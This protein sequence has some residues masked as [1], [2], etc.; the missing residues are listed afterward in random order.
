MVVSK[1]SQAWSGVG[2]KLFVGTRFLTCRPCREPGQR[3]LTGFLR[4]PLRTPPEHYRWSGPPSRAFNPRRD[5]SQG[6]HI[7]CK[8]F[9]S[10]GFLEEICAT[11]QIGDHVAFLV[12]RSQVAHEALWTGIGCLWKRDSAAERDEAPLQALP[13]LL[14]RN[15]PS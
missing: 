4:T 11:Q 8:L 10:H 9:L 12:I 5:R 15:L 14:H 2:I 1:V 6:A 13:T 7:E 3:G